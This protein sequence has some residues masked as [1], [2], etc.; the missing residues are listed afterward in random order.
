MLPQDLIKTSFMSLRRKRSRSALTML[1]IIIGIGAVILMLSIGKG[2]EGLI[3]SQ[4]A[5]FGSDIIYI[6]PGSGDMEEQASAEMTAPKT[7]TMDDVEAIK[8]LSSIV[9]VAPMLFSNHVIEW[10]GEEKR[11]QVVGTTPENKLLFPADVETGR[12]ITKND[13]DSLSQVAV[14]GSQLKEDL[15]GDQDPLGQKIKIGSIKLEVIGVLEV[16]GTKFFQN[17]DAMSY[18]PITT[19]QKKVLG[20]EYVNFIAAKTDQPLDWAKEDIRFL[21]RDEHNLDNPEGDLSKDDFFISSQEDAVAIVGT[22]SAVL[23]LLL[24]SI[25][26]ISLLVGGIGIMN[27]MLVSVT[28]RT[29]EIGLRKAIG[30]TYSEILRQFLLESVMLTMTGGIVGVISGV[31]LSYLAYLIANTQLDGWVFVVSPSSIIL[32]VIVSTA[33]GIAFGIY[34][35]RRAAR[36]DPIEALRYE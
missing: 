8:D 24:S 7:L 13:I 23:A 19:L 16:Q 12:F 22:V 32:A 1:G 14:L 4:V 3:L 11:A 5:E 36:L 15:F 6:E 26:A 9:E 31:T 30:A 27:I 35:A 18:V 10:Q 29:K 34:P 21:L 20:V 2:A 28:E 17:L 25:A 33:V